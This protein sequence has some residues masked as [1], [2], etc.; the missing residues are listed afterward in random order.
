MIQLYI[1]QTI[2]LYITNGIYI[3]IIYL[4]TIYN[5]Q[6]NHLI[7]SHYAY[8]YKTTTHNKL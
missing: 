5:I 8:T 7:N 3:K 6:Y 1:I 4:Y 2:Q